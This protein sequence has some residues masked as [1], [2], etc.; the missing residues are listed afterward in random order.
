MDTGRI[1]IANLAKGQIGH[2]KA[3]LLGS[4]LVT[5]FQLAAMARSRPSHCPS[6]RSMTGRSFGP[7][8]RRATAAIMRYSS[9]PTSGSMTRS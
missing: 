4:L 6:F 9:P 2:D 8:T 7:T 1:F 3:N 5:Q